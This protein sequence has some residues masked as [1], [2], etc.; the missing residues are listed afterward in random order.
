MAPV[1]SAP[2]TERGHQE[3]SALVAAYELPGPSLRVFQ[4]CAACLA[5][6]GRDATV[7][8]RREE[9]VLHGADDAHSAAMQ[10]AFRRKFFRA[11]PLSSGVRWAEGQEVSATVPARAILLALKGSQQR[12]EH[13][14]V[15]L[16]DPSKGEPRLVLEFSARFGV[17]V[18]HRVPLIENDAFLPGEPAAGPHSAALSP[19]LLSRI[20]DHCSPPSKA[21]GGCEEITLAAEPQE[22]LRI[23]SYDLMGGSVGPQANRTEVLLQRSDLEV[24][25]LHQQGGE[26]TFSGRSL[27]EFAK[28]AEANGKDLETLGLSD[29]SP[30]LELK[31]GAE[32]GTVVCTAAVAIDG[33]VRRPSDYSAVLL[34][35]TRELPIEPEAAPPPEVPAAAPPTATQGVQASTRRPQPRQGA[36]RRAVGSGAALETFDAFP[37]HISTQVSS[38]QAPTARPSAPA[39]SPSAAAVPQQAQPPRPP[40]HQAQPPQLQPQPQQFWQPRTMAPP[41]QQQPVPQHQRLPQHQVQQPQQLRPTG[42]VPQ[43]QQHLS[44]P[45]FAEAIRAG[46]LPPA[47]APIQP[48]PPAFHTSRPPAQGVPAALAPTQPATTGTQSGQA[49]WQGAPPAAGLNVQLS[50]PVTLASELARDA[51]QVPDSDDDDELVGPDPDEV[52]DD[53]AAP[54]ESA[55]WFNVDN[56]W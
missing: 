45:V 13:L 48:A 42:A 56:L 31:F 18:R 23:R 38:T 17:M 10:F 37:D 8:L 24:C 52:A 16:S 33:L 53:G 43:E 21:G 47:A 50:Q 26:V 5:K 6:L 41:P 34:V 28:I 25:T 36:K 39:Q 14:I 49:W 7:I 55:D 40:L 51:L 46:G 4:R 54:E 3:A 1:M 22:G 12:A 32:G 19:A 15:G 20:L 29:G 2:V 9:L 44:Q 27:R 11:T 35:A 30:L